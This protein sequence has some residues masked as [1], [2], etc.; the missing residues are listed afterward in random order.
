MKYIDQL[1]L[2]GKRVFIRADLN[3]P[4]DES[5][6]VADDNRINATLPTVNYALKNGASVVLASHLGRPKGKP[7]EAFSLK[8]VAQRISEITGRPVELAPDCIGEAVT[9]LARALRPGQILLLE[10]LRFHKEEEGNDEAFSKALAALADVYVNDAFA[11]AHRAHASTAGMTK[12]FT[13]KAGGFTLKA[14]LEY[15]KKAF[16][17][18]ARPLLAIFGGAKVS[19]K[20]AAIKHVGKKSNQIIVG[21]AMANTFLAAEGKEVGSSLYE[22]DLV[23]EAKKAKEMLAQHGCEL[24]LPVDVVVAQELKSG[25]PTKVVRADQIEPGWKALD[26]GPESSKLFARAIHNAATIIWNGP[27]GAFET[28]EFS[29]GTYSMVDALVETK[30]L[31]VVGGGDTD[32]ALHNKGAME[33]M[34]YVSTAGGAFLE[35]LEGRQLPGVVALG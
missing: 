12:F 15:F 3:V 19:T 16:D 7:D 31:T 26:I 25:V 32:L 23:D 8:P 29:A 9:A 34:S 13:E 28:E 21:G 1:D 24:L 18:P 35:L 11:T 6:A 20:I 30:G 5:G 22:A 27:M 33:K 2:S 14:E 4:I 17:E 10:N